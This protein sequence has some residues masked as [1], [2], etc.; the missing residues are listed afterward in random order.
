[1]IS[2][3]TIDAIFNAARIEEV[4]EEFVPLKKRGINMI[5]LCPFHDEK[6]PSFT[7]SPTRNIYK[8]FGCGKGGNP[9]N[10]IMEHEGSSYPEALRHLAAK[11][12]IEIKESGL[13]ADYQEEK[14]ERDS[15]FLLNEFA[16]DFYVK[17]L[18]ETDLGKSIGLSYFKDRG[19]L[20]KTIEK[21][22][23]GFAPSGPG[24]LTQAAV[25]KG[26]NI[27]FLRK[28]GLTTEKDRDFFY[29]RVMFPIHNANGKVV[30]FAGRQLTTQK[31]SPKY[32]NSKESD[33]YQKSKVLYAMNFAKQAIR[34]EGSC[35]LVEGYTDVLA[36]HQAGIE[37]VVAASGT[38]LTADQIR[39][40]KRYTN[41][42]RLLYDGDPAGVKAALRGIDLILQQD[43]NVEIVMLPEGED[44][45]S[46]LRSQGTNTFKQYVEENA[47]DFILF[48]TD[49][50]LE[51]TG[52]DPIKK[53]ELIK[54]IVRS[55]AHIT[56]PIKRSVYL[57]Q[58]SGQLDVDEDLL[59]SET[60]QAI[61]KINRDQRID[62]MRQARSEA[63]NRPLVMD[64]LTPDEAK[65]SSKSKPGVDYQERDIA[66]IL[67]LHG[68]KLIVKEP[69]PVQV[70]SYILAQIQEVIPSFSDALS[71]KIALLYGQRLANGEETDT[72]YFIYHTDPDI[73]KLASDFCASPYEYSENWKTMWDIHLQTQPMPEENEVQDSIQALW[74]FMLKRYQKL[75]KENMEKIEELREGT[76]ED[77]LIKHLEVQRMIVTKRNEIAQKLNTVIL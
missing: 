6:T 22:R 10:F 63:R 13:P 39:L 54:D 40:I 16:L 50:V 49:L 65:S 32:I 28:L 8:C 74:R 52:K 64:G 66:R 23:L 71:A 61:N 36:L 2:Q 27:E 73:S 51:E 19:L 26:Y 70:A 46:Y 14:N 56:D 11:Y 3:E 31:R 37:H 1:M 25:A 42:V 9:V 75:S 15:L 53:T 77:E 35:I 72:S 43:L 12:Q 4:V 7:V 48:K 76:N 55:L 60:N 30:A 29:N 59:V 58:C 5:G 18:H 34:K 44:P 67:I 38:A 57:R 68:H 33:I 45:D 47:K 69:E 62:Q 20:L 41:T 17:Q 24:G 21:F